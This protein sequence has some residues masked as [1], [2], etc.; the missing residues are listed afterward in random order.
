MGRDLGISW[1]PWMQAKKRAGQDPL[2]MTG[3]SAGY[4]ILISVAC[5]CAGLLGVAA[6]FISTA[7]A[8]IVAAPAFAEDAAQ[9][10][11]QTVPS[12]GGFSAGEIALVAAPILFYGLFSLYRDQ[13]NPKVRDAFSRAGVKCTVRVG[14]YV[15]AAPTCLLPARTAPSPAPGHK[16]VA[17]PEHAWPGLGREACCMWHIRRRQ[18]QWLLCMHARRQPSLTLPTS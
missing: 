16:A 2:M 10:A 8:V 1:S 5:C 7:T 12:L 15:G 18:R 6:P 14:V 3:N 13:V 17:W 11:A 4:R 9:E